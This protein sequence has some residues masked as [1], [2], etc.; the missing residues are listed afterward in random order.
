MTKHTSHV[1]YRWVSPRRYLIITSA[2]STCP[3]HTN[4]GR[5]KERRI[6]IG[7]WRPAKAALVR[8]FLEVYWPCAG[9]LSAVNAIGPQLR[10][11]IMRSLSV[12]WILQSKFLNC[13]R[14]YVDL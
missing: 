5:V 10:D 7:P 9:G 8:N 6:L 1:V 11:P 13:V 14:S 3:F 4:S 2:L 12:V